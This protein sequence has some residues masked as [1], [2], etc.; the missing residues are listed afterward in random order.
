MMR[1]FIKISRS[2]GWRKILNFPPYGGHFQ[3][4]GSFG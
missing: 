4:C 2:L 1:L 3:F